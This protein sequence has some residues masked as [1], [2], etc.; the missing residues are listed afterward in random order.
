MDNLEAMYW[1]AIIQQAKEGNKEAQE[2]LQVENKIRTGKG[3]MTVEDELREIAE[4]AEARQ[5]IE[6]A[7]AKKM[8]QK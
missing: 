3:L 5:K 4:E 2:M 8:Q 7:K 1:V 6:Q